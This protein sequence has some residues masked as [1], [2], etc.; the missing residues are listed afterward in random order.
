MT[1]V[2]AQTRLAI[3]AMGNEAM[4]DVAT[5]KL[6]VDAGGLAIELFSAIK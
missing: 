3:A 2:D 1:G 5:Q 6:L 4:K